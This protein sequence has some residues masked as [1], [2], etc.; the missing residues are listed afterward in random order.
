MLTE[1]HYRLKF[2]SSLPHSWRSRYLRWMGKG[3]FYDCE[4]LEM[5]GLESMLAAA[6]LAYRN[7]CI[8]GWRATFDIERPNQ[9]SI[10][11]LA[12]IPN[13]MLRPLLPV[14][15]TLIYRVERVA[16]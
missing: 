11:I 12:A 15:P 6:G 16:P 7:L 3:E 5:R 4:P 10:R 9:L 14:I 8:E 13:S 2:L 1:P